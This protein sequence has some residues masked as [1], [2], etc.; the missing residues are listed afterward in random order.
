MIRLT[1][2]RQ[3][4]TQSQ[5]GPLIYRAGHDRGRWPSLGAGTGTG[6]GR[7]RHG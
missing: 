5:T 7:L 2:T 1:L 6:P 4:G 3:S